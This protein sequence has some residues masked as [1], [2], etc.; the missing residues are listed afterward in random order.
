MPTSSLKAFEAIRAGRACLGAGRQL[1]SGRARI[2]KLVHGQLQAI[3]DPAKDAEARVP[4][5]ALDLRDERPV[6]ARIQG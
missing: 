5:A 4:D 6:D 3:G 2:E 1:L